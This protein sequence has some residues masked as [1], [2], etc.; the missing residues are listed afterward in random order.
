MFFHSLLD[1]QWPHAVP[2]SPSNPNIQLTFGDTEQDFTPYEESTIELP[3]AVE[4]GLGTTI[5]FEN[6]KI[7]NRGK[8]IKL[9]SAV[10]TEDETANEEVIKSYIGFKYYPN[11]K[12]YV[13]YIEKAI[14]TVEKRANG[15][16]SYGFVATVDIQQIWTKGAL[17]LGVDNST[18][19][20]LDCA[21]Y[22]DLSSN[23]TTWANGLNA[24]PT[25]DEIL[26]VKKAFHTFLQNNPVKIRYAASTSTET[27]LGAG[28]L[29]SYKAWKNGTETIIQG[30]IDNSEYGANPKITQTYI[31]KVGGEE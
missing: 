5:D 13:L 30:D 2:D 9:Q 22:L 26:A 24:E 23:S 8:E 3:T 1:L 6:R 19:Y 29:S 15:V 17:W 21:D 20:W 12:H 31:A 14:P 27:D 11:E 16:S 10:L 7:I 18:V 28:V 25:A 4:S